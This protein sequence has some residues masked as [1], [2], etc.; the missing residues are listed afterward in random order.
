MDR[1]NKPMT[2]GNGAMYRCNEPTA[3]YDVPLISYIGSIIRSNET[4]SQYNGP[5][6]RYDAPLI[7]YDDPLIRDP[8][9]TPTDGGPF[10]AYGE[11]SS[12]SLGSSP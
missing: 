3:P 1:D 11:A 2:R 8:G 12:S 10:F 6:N 9:G 5:L 7:S 4:L